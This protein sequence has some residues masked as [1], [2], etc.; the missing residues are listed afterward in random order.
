M[1]RSQD[2]DRGVAQYDVF[3]AM[4]P[5][6]VHSESPCD[7][8]R[9]DWSRSCHRSYVPLVIQVRRWRMFVFTGVVVALLLLAMGFLEGGFE[10]SS[11][12]L[13]YDQVE[14]PRDASWLAWH[15][16]AARLE[17]LNFYVGTVASLLAKPFEVA[18]MLVLPV[19]VL[20]FLT[21]ESMFNDSLAWRIGVLMLQGVFISFLTNGFSTINV[22]NV[23]LLVDRGPL[24]QLIA[25]L[26]AYLRDRIRLHA[27]ALTDVETPE[28]EAQQHV[29]RANISNIQRV[30]TFS[31]GRLAWRWLDLG[32]AFRAKCE[33]K[34]LED[35]SGLAI[36]LD[37][38]G[39]LT[40]SRQHVPMDGLGLVGEGH[41]VGLPLISVL[42]NV[43]TAMFLPLRRIS[44]VSKIGA[45]AEWPC[46]REWDHIGQLVERNCLSMDHGVQEAVT[47]ALFRLFQRGVAHRVVR[48]GS[49]TETLAF[50]GNVLRRGYYASVPH[51]SWAMSVIAGF[52]LVL[53][54]AI[55]VSVASEPRERHIAHAMDVHRVARVHL[56][57]QFFPK[58]FLHCA[59]HNRSQDDDPRERVQ[60]LEPF[61][62]VAMTLEH[63]RSEG[64]IIVVTLP[65]SSD[66]SSFPITPT[67]C[68]PRLGDAESP[69]YEFL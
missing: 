6:A 3:P 41:N 61:R 12:T 4:R 34:T 54:V 65:P 1:R 52:L 10:V 13:R 17:A 23:T 49:S 46:A 45:E 68:S 51:K 29:R 11:E 25:S 35:C 37:G 26:I 67:V 40:V 56:V 14:D 33:V 60:S 42:D 38:G 5:S 31:V 20:L 57:E 59:L 69:F 7:I 2:L 24:L 66:A 50:R 19:V 28:L 30:V 53:S 16:T 47:A 39:W 21:Q 44:K 63:R 9:P 48:D 55:V 58:L 8:E 27:Q 64:D 43:D 18:A 32:I 15:N 36:P 62:I 22:Q